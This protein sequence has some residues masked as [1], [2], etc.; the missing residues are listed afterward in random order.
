MSPGNCGQWG[1][2]SSTKRTISILHAN[3]LS[4]AV[5]VAL[6]VPSLFLFALRADIH[7]KDVILAALDTGLLESMIILLVLIGGILAHELIHGLFFSL[8]AHNGWKAISFGVL[9][10][11][12]TPY[13]HCSASPWFIAFTSTDGHSRNDSALSFV[14]VNSHILLFGLCFIA[15]GSGDILLVLT[16][17]KEHGG[18]HVLDLKDEVGYVIF[19][20]S[21]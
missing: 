17:R 8:Y 10:Q 12:I 7:V 21:T 20:R 14:V 15:A 1:A 4:I 18:C 11:Y 13:C 19:H 9:W 3:G 2:S 5:L 6:G 16:L